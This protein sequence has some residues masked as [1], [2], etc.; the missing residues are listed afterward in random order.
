MTC[1][2]SERDHLR[3][4]EL[5]AD[6]YL[7]KPFDADLLTERLRHLLV[8]TPEMLSARRA[9]ELEKAALLDRLE[10]A[11]RRPPRLTESPA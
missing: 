6:E 2:T 10:S 7:T 4:W 9:A 3:G 1:R 11:M 8:S 5:G